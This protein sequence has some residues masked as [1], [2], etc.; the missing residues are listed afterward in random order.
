MKMM[1]LQCSHTFSLSL[2]SHPNSEFKYKLDDMDF[3]LYVSLY[4]LL[5]C[6]GRKSIA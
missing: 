6:D 3:V 2:F 4:L 5:K 1:V